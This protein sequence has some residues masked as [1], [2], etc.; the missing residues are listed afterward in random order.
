MSIRFFA[1][2]VGLVL[3][4]ATVPAVDVQ[5]QAIQVIVDGQPIAFDQPPIVI[6][7]RVLVPLRGV[8]ERLGAFVQ[9]DPRTNVVS[10]ARGDTQVQLTIG[11]RQA[12]VNGRVVS[13]DVPAMITRGRTLVPLRF[14]SEAMGARV[15][16]DPANS[17]VF[18]TS[19][20]AAPPGPPP[21][22]IPPVQTTPA[23]PPPATSS[24]VE[25]MAI[26][27]DA[28]ASPQRILVERGNA[29]H[30]FVVTRDTAITRTEVSTGQ[31]GAIS[32]DDVR[33]GDAVRVTADAAGRA[34]LIRVSVRDLTGRIDAITGRAIVLSDG[35]SF[36]FADGIRFLLN[37]RD[38][39]REQLR[40][41]MVVTLQLNP[42]TGQVLEVSARAPQVQPPAPPPPVE[43]L[44]IAS[45]THN[46]QGPLRAGS[47]VVATLRGTAGGVATFDIFGVVAGVPMRETSPGVYQGTYTVRPQDNVAEAVVLAHLRVGNQ[48]APL[49]QAGTP[50]T[51]DGLRPQIV[52]RNPAPGQAVGN[53]RPN[54][55]ILFTDPGGSGINPATSRLI[56][57]E[58]N[59]TTEATFTEASVVY[60]P[61]E[62]LTG[63]VSVR[64]ILSDRAGN[65]LDDRY[66]FSIAIPS[67]SLIRS[68]TVNP[69]TLRAGDVLTV[70]VVGEPG[71][72]ASFAIEGVED[73]IPLVEAGN[74]P[75]LYFGSYRVRRR[76]AAHNARVIV[77]LTKGG[78]TSRAEAT[79]RLTI[80]SADRLEPP[81]ITSPASG[82]RLDG[83]ITVRG[84]ATP[85]YRVEVQVDYQGSVLLFS[86]RGTYGTVTT[87]ADAAGN[88][89][90]TINQTMRVP[91]AEL[92]ITAVAIDPLN[93]RSEP[94]VMK[95]VVAGG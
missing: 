90:V 24:V 23:P 61:P 50:V 77:E 41:G 5:A 79:A 66:T 15:D 40:A 25:G 58:R 31:G 86:L 80:V 11:S 1:L 82:A 56:V 65:V 89:A 44:R 71:G 70:A 29:I 34:I 32:L 22:G 42:Q 92:T 78:A 28:Q 87:T 39:T 67:A 19:T 10:A 48:E 35:Q 63:Q 33:P 72:R 4:L 64:V 27:V 74:Q 6:G 37:G 9:W 8:F 76:N 21:P 75:G 84:T 13:L 94:A 85:G 16:W 93:R 95:A 83:P 46:A 3:A 69:T 81:V 43:T 30:T 68:V 20:Q 14:V 59:V 62:P 7:G 88:W 91:N 45:F 36:T 53:A 12:F 60:N 55:Q 47:T 57:N 38:A 51:I 2:A 49:V 17:A 52:Q 26:R 73:A 18:V 54:I